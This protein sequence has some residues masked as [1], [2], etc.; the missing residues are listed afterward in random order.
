MELLVKKSSGNK[1]YALFLKKS[2]HFALYEQI[3]SKANTQ[4]VVN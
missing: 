2:L 1:S 3:I 4:N